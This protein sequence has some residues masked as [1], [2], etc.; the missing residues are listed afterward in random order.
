MTI[1]A[2]RRD[3]RRSPRPVSST[4]AGRAG[5]APRQRRR[6][7]LPRRSSRRP[8][9]AAYAAASPIDRLPLGVPL[10]CVH[11]RADDIVPISQSEDFVAAARAA[12]DD[13]ELVAVDGDHFVV[14]DPASDAWAA[15]LDFLDG[16]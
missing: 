4:S 15:V 10:L 11:G 1:A 7:S 3:G 9:A 2:V 12:G 5:D 16:R 14:I 13:A 6:A 8:S